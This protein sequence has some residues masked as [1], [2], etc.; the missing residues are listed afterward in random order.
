MRR[1]HLPDDFYLS[2]TEFLLH[3]KQQIVGMSADYGLSSMQALTLLLSSPSEPRPM[4]SFC[5]LYDCDA[6]NVTGIVDGLEQKGLVSRQP[7][8]D[9]RR[10]KII[11]LEPAGDKLRR[12][13]ANRL[14]SQ[15]D[16][17]F[18]GLDMHEIEQLAG[19]IQKVAVASTPKNVCPVRRLAHL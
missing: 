13:I 5:K 9:D 10:I 1:T 16:S 12:E 18:N 17:L 8:P 3:A 2:L 14:S 7:H 11:Q 6:S 19:L 4:N 15:S